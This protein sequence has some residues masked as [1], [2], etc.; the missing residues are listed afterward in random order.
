MDRYAQFCPTAKATGVIGRRWM[1]LA[2]RE[3]LCGN[4]QLN[5]IHR[6]VPKMSRTLL[7]KR[8]TELEE[9]GLIERRQSAGGHS[10]Y[11]LTPAGEA[12]RPIVIELGN[13]GKRWVG[14]GVSQSD[15]DAGLLMWDI[16]RRIERERLPGRRVVVHFRFTDAPQKYRNFW[17]VL[18]K[19]KVDLCL[20][21]PGFEPDLY[22]TSDLATFTRIWLGD[23]A[24]NRALRDGN[25][26]VS[27]ARQL[28]RQFPHWLGLNLFAGVARERPTS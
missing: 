12:L 28:R 18:E 25:L 4:H 15:L 5:D 10:E 21:D 2:L 20:K 16:Q 1:L 14:N 17:L 8:L 9:D 26:S 7:V 19:D 23:I 24:L 22:V 3:L 27:G 11:H 6:G 13:W